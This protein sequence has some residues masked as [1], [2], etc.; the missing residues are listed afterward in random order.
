MVR[1]CKCATCHGLHTL[2]GQKCLHDA[3]NKECK[4]K[5][6]SY[7]GIYVNHIRGEKKGHPNM[8]YI[9]NIKKLHP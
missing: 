1:K 4:G 5:V 2:P 8:Q 6:S 7:A 3:D 9:D